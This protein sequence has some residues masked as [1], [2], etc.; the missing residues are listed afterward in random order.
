MIALCANIVR[1]TQAVAGLSGATQ[2][3]YDRLV[4]DTFNAFKPSSRVPK[5]TQ[6]DLLEALG[7]VG[8]SG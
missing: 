8:A 4:R 3:R 6:L 7:K 1:D 5:V 2:S